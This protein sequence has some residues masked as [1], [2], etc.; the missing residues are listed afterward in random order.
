MGAVVDE[1]QFRMMIGT[2]VFCVEQVRGL[3]RKWR[4]WVSS[5]T[6]KTCQVVSK[7]QCKESAFGRFERKWWW[8]NM[9]RKIEL[10]KKVS[11]VNGV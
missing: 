10:I 1:P 9:R 6:P 8:R 5:R 7:K 4:N 2:F 11:S 3:R